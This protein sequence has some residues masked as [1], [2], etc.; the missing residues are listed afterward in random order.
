MPKKGQISEKNNT[1]CFVLNNYQSVTHVSI[2]IY[3]GF[4]KNI[5]FRSVALVTKKIFGLF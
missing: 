2:C 1:F 4:F 5:V 3:Q